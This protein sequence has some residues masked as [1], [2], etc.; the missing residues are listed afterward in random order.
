MDNMRKIKLAIV[1]AAFIFAGVSAYASTK[2]KV[3]LPS[4]DTGVCIQNP[5][6][7]CCI[8]ANNNVQK[9]DFQPN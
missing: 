8:D 6:V 9:G 5:A 2:A 7:Q 3:G 1:A 4:C